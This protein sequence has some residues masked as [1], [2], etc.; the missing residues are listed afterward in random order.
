MNQISLFDN[1][2]GGFPKRKTNYSFP[3]SLKPYLEDRTGKQIQADRI[4]SLIASGSSCIKEL[5]EKT[6]LPSS[7]VSGRLADLIKDKRVKYS[8]TTIYK[9]RLRK[10]IVILSKP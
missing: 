10:K 2:S 4:Y 1:L 3:T 7:T 5:S 8:G 9:N 6:N